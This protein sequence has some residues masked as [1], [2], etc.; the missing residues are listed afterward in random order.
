M[1]GGGGTFKVMIEMPYS[2]LRIFSSSL[3][4]IWQ[5]WLWSFKFGATKSDVENQIFRF[6]ESGLPSF[7]ILKDIGKFSFDNVHSFLKVL[8]ILYPGT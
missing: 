6:F 2:S 3:L 4:P 8:V 1:F 7:N 5:N